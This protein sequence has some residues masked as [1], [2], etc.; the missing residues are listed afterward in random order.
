MI[1]VDLKLVYNNFIEL[2]GGYILNLKNKFIELK[3]V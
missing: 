2:R 3:L 1:T